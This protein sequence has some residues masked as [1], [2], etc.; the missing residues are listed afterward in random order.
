MDEVEAEVG[1]NILYLNILASFKWATDSEK[2]SI[3]NT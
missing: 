1:K 3:R 2:H